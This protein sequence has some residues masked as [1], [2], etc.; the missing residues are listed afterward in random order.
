MLEEEN[1]PYHWGSLIKKNNRFFLFFRYSEFNAFHKDL[2]KK[3]DQKL[4]STFD[5]PPKKTMG[6]KAEK[7]VEDRRKRLQCYLRNVVNLMVHTNPSLAAKPDKEHVLDF[8]PFFAENFA[9]SLRRKGNV[10]N[11]RPSIF[12]NRRGVAANTTEPLAL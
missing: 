1:N 10:T 7:V 5:F 12:S 8:F 3:D 11:Q 9:T 4:V 6:N 2:I